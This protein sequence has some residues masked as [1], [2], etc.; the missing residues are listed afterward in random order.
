[1]I[2]SVPLVGVIAL[3]AIAPLIALVQLL[4]PGLLG[5]RW[6]QYRVAIGV[7]L[8][9]STLTFLHWGLLTW[10]Y[11][12]PTWWLSPAALTWGLAGVAAV[13]LVGSLFWRPVSSEHAPAAIERFALGGLLAA[14][15]LWLAFQG[16]MGGS[17]VDPMLVL[18]SACAIGLIH[19]KLRSFWQARGFRAVASTESAFLGT[20]ALSGAALAGL[21]SFDTA[22]NQSV[23]SLAGEW[24][25]FRVDVARSGSTNPADAGPKAPRLLWPF[26]RPQVA[27]TS[28]I[29]SSP[30][31][32]DGLVFLGARVEISASQVGHIYCV[33]ARP[34]TD[35]DR[36][37]P[38]PRSLVWD[39]NI[40]SLRPVF[41]SAAVS[42]GRVYI[43]EGYHDHANCRLFCLDGRN[44]QVR[45]AFRTSSH[46]ES[47]PTIVGERVYF[48]AGDD[49]LYCLNSPADQTAPP[50]IRWH[51]Q[52]VHVDSSPLVVGGKVFAG[53]VVGDRVARLEV[54]SLDAESGDVL[55][56]VPTELPV[57][58]AVTYDG[59][60][61]LIA[62][63]NGKL[64]AE[65]AQPAGAIRRLNPE[66]GDQLWE[67]PL[68][69]SVLTSPIAVDGRVY[70]VA[71]NGQCYCLDGQTGQRIWKQEAGEDVVSSPI[72]S[73]GRMYVVTAFGSILCLEAESGAVVWQFDELRQA[74][75]TVY[76][77][78]ALVDGR[79]Y[80]AAGGKLYC[81]G[82]TEQP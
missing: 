81:V 35:V 14:S 15:T 23:E 61:V 8:S 78:P 12:E 33:N 31:V 22:S 21:L 68:A 44:G 5:D 67:F 76:S 55:W 10:V 16:W 52:G 13:G 71:R 47:P 29:D 2:E 17:L 48:G 70:F 9:Q 36:E 60:A 39:A 40:E 57:P 42:Q 46:V 24:T 64:N 80:L 56:R 6:K 34:G 82:E 20:L 72:V 53:G 4:F 3:P 41:A 62:M 30:V 25:T 73:G 66:N 50:A 26:Q 79:L 49:G 1:M 19:L 75:P 69:S 63:G 54:F 11:P 27:G 51:L 37:T 77:S 58:A 74:S 59:E 18:A 7:L 65:A 45:W 43:G 38:I 28:S 32:V